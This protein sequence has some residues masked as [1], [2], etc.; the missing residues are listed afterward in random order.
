VLPSLAAWAGLLLLLLA[1]Y[2][3]LGVLCFGPPEPLLADDDVYFRTVPRALLSLVVCLTTANFPDVMLHAYKGSRASFL[4]FASFLL[5]GLFFLMSMFLAE[6]VEAYKRQLEQE[7]LFQRRQRDDALRFAFELLDFNGNGFVERDEIRALLSRLQRPVP[8]TFALTD[9]SI[10]EREGGGVGTEASRR[11]SCILETQPA[12]L[13]ARGVGAEHFRSLLI[14]LKEKDDTAAAAPSSGAPVTPAVTPAVAPLVAAPAPAGTVA[15]LPVHQ[16]PVHELATEPGD[17]NLAAMAAM[18][19]RAAAAAA[20]EDEREVRSHA[21]DYK[22]NDAP[23]RSCAEWSRHQLRHPRTREVALALVLLLDAALLSVEVD[24]NARAHDDAM[25]RL[26]APSA[27][28]FDTL[29]LLELLMKLAL[30]GGARYARYASH[31]FDG[32]V[33]LVTVGADAYALL[34]ARTDQALRVAM[35]LR[36]LRLLRLVTAIRSFRTIFGRFV[37]MLPRLTGLF[38][39]L[40]SVFSI[41]A[42]VGVLAFGG[43]IYH[44]DAFERTANVTGA[45]PLYTYCNF[46]DF[47]SAIVTL[48]ELLVVNNW[49][50][51]MAAVVVVDGQWS[52]W[53]FFSWWVVAVLV[54]SNLLVAFIL[55]EMHEHERSAAAVASAVAICAPPPP[56]RAHAAAAS[57]PSDERLPPTS[58]LASTEPT[59]TATEEMAAPRGGLAINHQAINHQ[60]SS[61]VGASSHL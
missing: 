55:E 54:F 52:R 4:F 33:T 43:T 8:S 17:D 18:A 14:A 22:A 2:A 50:V 15:P 35:A 36:T 24:R 46:N 16:L 61:Q 37:H 42:Q 49:Q 5:I 53:Y 1:L 7:R 48:F 58:S 12:S 34:V 3:L 40:W 19:A 26:E 28:A 39:A 13:P 21:D 44:G 30:L 10:C 41:Y 20:R 29:Y 25:R 11:L 6:I 60:A 23:A 31:A 59:A 32:A 51:V 38:G 45:D 47:G 9:P 56:P 27:P 57:A